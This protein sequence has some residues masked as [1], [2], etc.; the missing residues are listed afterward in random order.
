MVLDILTLTVERV[1]HQPVGLVLGAV[2]TALDDVASR[3]RT[4]LLGQ[5]E[6]E[7]LHVA[8]RKH[9]FEDQLGRLE[10]HTTEGRYLEVE[11]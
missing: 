11:V 6:A 1:V 10:L 5:A 7:A 4:G 2:E 9:G 3:S 8:L